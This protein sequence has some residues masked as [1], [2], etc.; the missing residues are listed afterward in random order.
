MKKVLYKTFRDEFSGLSEKRKNFLCEFNWQFD[1]V[2]LKDFGVRLWSSMFNPF[3]VGRVSKLL[4]I[5]W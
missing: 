3:L 1:V 2:K 5:I 4:F